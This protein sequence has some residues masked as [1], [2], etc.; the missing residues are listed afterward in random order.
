[1]ASTST[2][3]P[4]N[5][6]DFI[7]TVKVDGIPDGTECWIDAAPSDHIGVKFVP[8]A[9]VIKNG[10]LRCLVTNQSHVPVTISEDQYIGEVHSMSLG[11]TRQAG[12]SIVGSIDVL[13]DEVHLVPDFASSLEI[14]NKTQSGNIPLVSD[15]NHSILDD[16]QK[17]AIQEVINS[18]SEAFS[19]HEADFGKTQLMEFVIEL[20]PGAKPNHERPYSVPFHRREALTKIINN[21]LDT[22]RIAKSEASAFTS[23]V[24]LIEKKGSKDLRMCVDYRKLNAVTVKNK[25]RLPTINDVS[26]V[27]GQKKYFTSLDLMSGYWQIA[28]EQKSADLTTFVLPNYETY[29]FKVLPFGLSG[30]P[31]QF[32]RLMNTVLVDLIRQQKAICYVDDILLADETF[33]E[34]LKTLDF[35]FKRL[36][37][38]GLKLKLSKAQF[39]MSELTFLGLTISLGCIKPAKENVEKLLNFPSPKDRW[40]VESLMG[41]LNYYRRHIKNFASLAA[42]IT[43]LLRCAKVDGD[44]GVRKKLRWTEDAEEA[45][46]VLIRKITS[47]PVL[48]FPIHDLNHPY[49]LTTDASRIAVAGALGQVQ[50]ENNEYPISFFSKRLDE[51]QGCWGSSEIELFAIVASINHFRQY[52]VGTTFKVFTDNTGCLEILRKPNLS[53]KLQRWSLML[54]DFAFSLHHKPGKTNPVDGLSR[55]HWV[56]TIKR[57]LGPEEVRQA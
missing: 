6:G 18:N 5:T 54:G 23:P 26:A 41:M 20:L 9:D 21:L 33:E 4:A 10:S 51:T 43:D 15:L 19:R 12:D 30:A 56:N 2:D 35:C 55:I 31:S 25:Q 50:G 53:G 28:M 38:C 34:H 7:F 3:I 11:G 42:P 47:Y 24:V 29:K 8:T 14:E 44:T 49:T 16:E 1:M 46:R 13:K 52:L 37:H 48:R 32:Q 36:V 22:G 45:M 27:L 17:S 40:G 57:I 39:C